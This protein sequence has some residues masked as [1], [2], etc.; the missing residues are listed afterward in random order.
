VNAFARSLRK[1]FAA[2]F[3]GN[4]AL[5]YSLIGLLRS[6][7]PPLARKPGRPG[8]AVVTGALKLYSKRRRA[9]P[10]E[11]DRERWAAIY[12]AVIEGHG[13]MKQVERRDAEQ[14]L[15]DR[16]RWRLRWHRRRKRKVRFAVPHV[17]EIQP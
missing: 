4:P 13:Q 10:G 7:L 3:A 17:V 15:R 1:D 12:T 5:K 14:L 8:S 16:V 2:I 11:S 9:F 6:K